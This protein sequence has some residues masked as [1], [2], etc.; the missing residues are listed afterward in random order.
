MVTMTRWQFA[1]YGF[2]AAMTGVFIDRGL[3][4]IGW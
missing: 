1:D 3:T 2:F 4:W